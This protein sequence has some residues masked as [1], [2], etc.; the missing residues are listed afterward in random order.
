[1]HSDTRWDIKLWS[2][3]RSRRPPLSRSIGPMNFLSESQQLA[4][5]LT[6]S[7]SPNAALELLRFLPWPHSP[8]HFHAR[9]METQW[10]PG[11]I[12]SDGSMSAIGDFAAVKAVLR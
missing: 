12:S 9:C 5:R 10:E 2:H 6:V 3:R 11:W 4:S 8:N 1:M 7:D